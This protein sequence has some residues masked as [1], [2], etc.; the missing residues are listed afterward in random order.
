MDGLESWTRWTNFEYSCVMSWQSCRSLLAPQILG[1]FRR[2]ETAISSFYKRLTGAIQSHPTHQWKVC[3]GLQIVFFKCFWSI[4]E[5]FSDLDIS[6]LRTIGLHLTVGGHW[7]HLRGS[8][9]LAGH[10]RNLFRGGA[11]ATA[12][13]GTSLAGSGALDCWGLEA[14]RDTR[15]IQ[16]QYIKQTWYIIQYVLIY[17]IL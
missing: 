12:H 4:L 15:M 3:N 6:Q 16:I 11:E 7:R 1:P 9:G 13:S 2:L 14:D 17:S 10:L 8:L 5:Y